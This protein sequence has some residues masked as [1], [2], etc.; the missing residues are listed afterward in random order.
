M[1]IM[2][3]KKVNMVY[4]HCLIG[5]GIMFLIRYLPMSLPE[6][7]PVGKQILG[8]FVGTLYLWTTVDP[9]WS[10]LLCIFMVGI[11]D[12]APMG[13]VLSTTFGNPTVV[14][15]FF[16]MIIMNS[17]QVNRLSAYIG[18]FFL[19]RKIIIGRPWVFTAVLFVGSVLI[20]AFV[21]C[22]A[23]IFLFWP[24]LYDIFEDIG[25]EKKE[26][27][28]TLMIIMIVV[29]CAIGFPVPPYMSNGLALISNYATITQNILGT[30]VVL[31][32]AEWLL[33]SLLYGA[34]CAAA[35]I[36]FAKY[37]LRPDVSKLKNL[38]LEQLNKNPLPPLSK[39]QK[40]VGVVCVCFLLSMLLPSIFPSLPGMAFISANS[41]G[42]A[43]F[44]I[45][46]LCVIQVDGKPVF[47]LKE[48]MEP[49]A[50]GTFF[51]VT[52]AI[53]LGG[54]LTNES[55]GVIPFLNTILAPVFKN[56]TPFVFSLLVLVV[57]CILT[58]ICNSLV[59]GMILQP[60]IATY[61]LSAGINSAPIAAMTSIF[62]LA[63]AI[64]TPAAS[65]FAAMLFGNKEWLRAKDIYK[66]DLMF[67]LIELILVLVVG[68]P[69][70]NMLVH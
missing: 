13:S 29:A 26:T 23:P 59:I 9:I 2:P 8:I 35:I 36:L 66:Y 31:N 48:N 30:S 12:Y 47:S 39:K 50:W 24:I 38:T 25:M 55:T 43:I 60:V 34:V 63:C 51:L 49:F 1:I 58:N 28:P 17:L 56:M 52:S 19:T 42:T 33:V 69:L 54:V 46:V 27:Y 11:S 68:L 45:V 32:N 41:L 18:R 67:V 61:C 53:L 10:S 64:A 4:I 70:A 44:F 22:F 15:M 14:Q 3:K 5:L 20:A 21:G 7:T 37:V 62:V 57:G 16:L 6:I 40:V 65:P